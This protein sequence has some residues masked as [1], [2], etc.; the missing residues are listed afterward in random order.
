M[1][2]NTIALLF[3]GLTLALALGLIIL[4][5][6]HDP[7]SVANRFFVL[8]LMMVVLWAGGSL[9]G[10]AAAFVNAGDGAIQTGLRLLDIG[11][12]GASVTIY[13]YSAVL[14]GE[15]GRLFRLSALGALAVIFGYHLL[16]IVIDTPR[17]F[18]VDVN[19]V[20][21]YEFGA[22]SVVLYLGFQLATVGLVWRNRQR[23]RARV[24][25][26][27]IIMFCV[28]QMLGLVSPRFR[29]LGVSE[30]VSAFAALM[31]SYALVRQQIMDPLLGRAR[32]LEVVRDVGLAIT[33][34]LHLQETLSAVAA[35]AAGLLDAD[36]A[37]IFL[38]RDR[39]L[40][41]AA[42]YNLPEQYVGDELAMGVGLVGTVA[43]ERRG[44]QVDNYQQDWHSVEDLPLAHA[45][46]GAMICVPLLFA[47]EVVG[48]LA[49]IE[50][51]RGRLF[52]REDMRLLELLGPQAAVAITNSRLFEAE[53]ALSN[54]VI[55]AKDQ[56]ETVLTSTEN[57]VVALNRQFR[58]IFANPAASKVLG[59]NTDPVGWL[60]TDFVPRGFLPPDPRRALRDLR[61]SHAHIYEVMIRQRTY[62]CHVAELGRPRFEGW[63]VVLN[64]VSQLKELDRLKSQMVQMTSHDLKN[65]L[66]AAMSYLELLVE[67]GEDLFDSEMHEYADHIWTH[68]AR[69]HR[70]IS[71]ILDLERVQSGT[72]A[73]ELCALD[74]VVTRVVG[75][76]ADQAR[77]KGLQLDVEGV[78]A[79]PPVLGDVNQI[80]Q[81][82]SNLVDN[83][84]KF[85]RQGGSVTVGL[86]AEAERVLVSVRDTG[87]GIPHEELARIF[88]RFYRVQ[89]HNLGHVT[90]S[91]LGLSLVKAIVDRHQG[92]IR[93]ESE[94]GEGTTFWVAFPRPMEA[95]R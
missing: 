17:T 9:L 12:S 79:P 2:A 69:M 43:V 51:L 89:H 81:A 49:V 19:G 31:M 90:G 18:E 50:G 23:I 42:V 21:I 91:G 28:G 13:L 16:L 40:K 3:N 52:D 62:L 46:F 92:E 34:R 1:T 72:P 70:I 66:Q 88:D 39:L 86:T 57:P 59:T 94:P 36:G 93:I 48:V 75:E 41:L 4:V 7:N 85:T 25:T 87:I 61:K 5:L 64:D 95:L 26:A 71:G 80:T 74:E 78:A 37:A 29:T 47:D 15:W 38:K 35:Q 56:L 20:L 10:R 27:G 24:L 11:F 65:P 54:E 14:T 6:W 33:S 63:V 83:A 82:L 77:S 44:R 60:I 8:F 53:R 76:Y 30:D 67:D 55:V 45:T 84:V 68:L 22:A 32:Q 58:I 73:F